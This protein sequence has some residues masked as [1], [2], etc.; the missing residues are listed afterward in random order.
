ME[1]KKGSKG[2]II[3]ACILALLIIL[4]VVAT[5]IVLIK[6]S[7]V[8]KPNKGKGETF[9][10]E[11]TS[12][13]EYK[14][15][16]D[17]QVKNHTEIALDDFS[18]GSV[19]SIPKDNEELENEPEEDNGDYVIA[20]SNSRLLTESDLEELTKE[21]LSYARNEIYARHGRIFDSQ[22]LQDYFENKDWYIPLYTADS[23]P[24]NELNEFEKENAELISQY[25]KENF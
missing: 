17:T 4:V 12:E 1:N 22:E 23:F 14:E 24:E 7:S 16:G 5:S 19:P 20:D 8:K 25:E 18:V 11:Q 10:T 21:E 15:E 13:E 3:I 2:E 6:Y 9:P